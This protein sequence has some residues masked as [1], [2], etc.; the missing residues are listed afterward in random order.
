M[1]E[2]SIC[3]IEYV[4]GG[5]W[6][7]DLVSN[8]ESFVSSMGSWLNTFFAGGSNS[9]S[10]SATQVVELSKICMQNGGSVSYNNQG[11]Q[12]LTGTM[13]PGSQTLNITITNTSGQAWSCTIK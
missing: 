4:S 8:T 3:E 13:K 10:L 2:L 11:Q 5:D 7:S 12:Q 6:L 9:T 1:R